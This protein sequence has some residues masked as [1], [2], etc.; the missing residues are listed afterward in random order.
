M[1][2]GTLFLTIVMASLALVACQGNEKNDFSSQNDV[3]PSNDSGD[4]VSRS[5][6]E[7]TNKEDPMG[8][9]PATSSST[10]DHQTSGASNSIKSERERGRQ[11]ALEAIKVGHPRTVFVGLPDFSAGQVDEKT[12]LPWSTLGCC[13]DDEVMAFMDGY[14]TVIERALAAGELEGM[15]Y[16][17][18]MMTKKEAIR[19]MS[20]KNEVLALGGDGLRS[21]DGKHRLLIETAKDSSDKHRYGTLFIEEIETGKREEMQLM[22]DQV[23]V[24]FIHDGETAVVEDST[25]INTYDLDTFCFMQGFDKNRK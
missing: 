5:Q 2:K 1:I 18:Q 9:G 4:V 13:I 15:T 23:N 3:A 24:V 21:P 22:F 7:S 11:A 16:K 6:G 25:C 10:G 17:S 20:A 19:A 8:N 14:N 12:G